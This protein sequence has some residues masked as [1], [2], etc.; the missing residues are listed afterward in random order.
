MSASSEVRFPRTRSQRNQRSS[1]R[2]N[3]MLSSWRRCFGI[4][5]RS[6]SLESMQCSQMFRPGSL[7]RYDQ[8]SQQRAFDWP[9]CRTILFVHD[10]ASPGI[11][12]RKTACQSGI[13]WNPWFATKQRQT[14]VSRL[15]RAAPCPS[16]SFPTS[17]RSSCRRMDGCS[18]RPR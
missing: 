17:T 1:G 3:T 15:T 18:A 2:M 5:R 4:G 16:R 11:G 10:T 14:S 12:S 7:P 6:S 13:E 9:V 8:G